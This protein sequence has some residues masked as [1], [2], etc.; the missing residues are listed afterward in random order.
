MGMFKDFESH[1]NPDLYEIEVYIT[2]MVHA[3]FP[4]FMTIYS[5]IYLTH[6]RRASVLKE[7]TVFIGMLFPTLYIIYYIVVSVI[8]FDPYGMTDLHFNFTKYIG[9]TPLAILGMY[10]MMGFMIITHNLI[11][12]R[13][14]KKYDPKNDYELKLRRKRKEEK[15]YTKLKK[16]YVLN[17]G[18][19]KK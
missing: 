9:L 18:W 17:G 2:V 16:K 14:N 10:T 1:F 7:R 8:W 3:A 15:I 19:H 11:L 12:F 4:L 6:D 13:F 5:F